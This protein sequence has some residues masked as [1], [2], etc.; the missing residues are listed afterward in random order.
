MEFIKNLYGFLQ[1]ENAKFRLPSP[2]P[3]L[4]KRLMA[5]RLENMEQLA[6]FIQETASTAIFWIRSMINIPILTNMFLRQ[7]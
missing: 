4:R 3:I 7:Q 6:F 1:I 5:Y 2:S